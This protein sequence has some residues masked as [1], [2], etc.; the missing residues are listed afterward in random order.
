MQCTTSLGLSNV[1]GAHILVQELALVLVLV[2]VLEHLQQ[3]GT[4]GDLP[5]TLEPSAAGRT[6]GALGFG[7]AAWR[8]SLV[9]GAASDP[10]S[11]M[12]RMVLSVR[13]VFLLLCYAFEG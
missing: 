6:P 13:P 11:V 8:K 10:L 5:G 1:L 4:A 3:G 7:G 12:E 9:H 2:L